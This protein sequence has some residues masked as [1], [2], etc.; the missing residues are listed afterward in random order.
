MSG[1]KEAQEMLLMARRDLKAL[2]HMRDPA[3]FDDAIFGFH[4]QQAI[5]KALKAWLSLRRRRYPLTHS[6]RALLALLEE[7][8]GGVG[9]F[10]HVVRYSVFAV[11]FRYEEAVPEVEFLDREAAIADAT[12]VVEH[13]ERLVGE[14]G[15]SS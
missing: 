15:S 10:M 12:A 14:A 11:Q 4:A 6:L 1:H 3:L 2:G 8:G 7:E 9:R 5:E 13:V